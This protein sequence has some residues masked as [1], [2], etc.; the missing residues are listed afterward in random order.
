MADEI[1]VS[2]DTARDLEEA[3][4]PPLLAGDL[5]AVPPG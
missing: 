4:A 2:I 1:Q 3:A 5:G